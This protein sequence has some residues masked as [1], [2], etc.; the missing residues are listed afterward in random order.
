L[1]LDITTMV[2][3]ELMTQKY[4]STIIY[5]WKQT[6]WHEIRKKWKAQ[7]IHNFFYGKSS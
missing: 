5:I 2:V 1:V 3:E 7:W 6:K 4:Q